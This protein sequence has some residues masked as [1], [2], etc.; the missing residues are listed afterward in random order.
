MAQRQRDCRLKNVTMYRSCV[1]DTVINV[2]KSK[3]LLIET[4][5]RGKMLS[6][7][8]FLIIGVLVPV[9]THP[10][11]SAA[12]TLFALDAVPSESSMYR[13]LPNSSFP[14][15][16]TEYVS[17]QGDFCIDALPVPGTRILHLSY[18]LSVSISEQINIVDITDG[19]F[20][21]QCMCDDE[22]CKINPAQSQSG[23]T[24]IVYFPWSSSIGAL[25]V[26][27]IRLQTKLTQSNNAREIS[28]TLVMGAHTTPIVTPILQWPSYLVIGSSV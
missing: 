14:P 22:I 23:Y 26:L 17:V 2:D 20:A 5:S 24:P 25:L 15:K 28:P 16:W 9:A 19:I 10:P 27:D 18:N 3:K 21:I 1:P 7:F 11:L 13:H 8:V 6:L 4:F 12:E